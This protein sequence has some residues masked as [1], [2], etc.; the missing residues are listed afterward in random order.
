MT[1][2]HVEPITLEHTAA[3][4]ATLGGDLAALT[5]APAL[6][7]TD[8]GSGPIAPSVETFLD[9]L[10]YSMAQL[11]THLSSLITRLNQ[12]AT[13]YETSELYIRWAADLS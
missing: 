8:L 1:R 12:A 7:G 11:E 2:F 4:L 9:H 5:E 6:S 13:N 3:A 10:G